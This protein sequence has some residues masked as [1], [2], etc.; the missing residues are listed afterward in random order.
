MNEKA[1]R[2]YNELLL[3][4]AKAK[5]KKSKNNDDKYNFTTG[6]GR[7]KGKKGACGGK[8]RFDGSGRG[9]GNFGTNR[10]PDKTKDESVDFSYDPMEELEMIAE[11][12]FIGEPKEEKSKR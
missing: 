10:Q 11:S 5:A 7:G 3:E 2:I 8:R 9:K 4:K 1:E 6:R 12:I